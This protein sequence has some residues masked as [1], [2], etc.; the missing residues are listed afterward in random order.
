[1]RLRDVMSFA[2]FAA[3]TLFALGYIGSL[4]VQS[5]LPPDRTDVSIQVADV[6]GLVAGSKVLFRG[7]PVGEVTHVEAAVDV[8]TVDFYIRE[9]FQIPVD[10][11]IRLENLSALGESYIG[12]RPRSEGGPTLRKGQRFSADRVTQPP[13]VSELA[14]SVVR[15]L[16]Q[17]D[18]VALGR[19]TQE[20]DTGL[21]DPNMVLPSLGHASRVLRNVTAGMD[22]RGQV[23]LGN[24]QTLLRNADWLGPVLGDLSPKVDSLGLGI[25][26]MLSAFPA[27]VDRGAPENLMKFNAF[28][29]RVQGL[30]DNNGGDLKVIGENFQPQVTGIA[31]ALLNF[32]TGQLLENMLA[33][34]PADGAITL[35]VTVPDK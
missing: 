1:M 28:L 16:D 22:G 3:M 20:L 34:V 27:L 31:G 21:P 5:G 32:D 13:S 33:G 4:G 25:R 8:A 2:A 11:D 23:L 35:H 26:S 19:I 15:V 14:T 9:P 10:S 17:L 6:N 12:F 18:P 29:A 30:L 24:F 7:V